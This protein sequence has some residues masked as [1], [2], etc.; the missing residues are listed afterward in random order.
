MLGYFFDYDIK[1]TKEIDGKV[2]AD[3]DTLK[4]GPGSSVIITNDKITFIKMCDMVP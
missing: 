4:P 3:L 1:D 2:Y